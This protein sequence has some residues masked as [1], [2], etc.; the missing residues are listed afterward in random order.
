MT[1]RRRD[2]VDIGCCEEVESVVDVLIVERRVEHYSKYCLSVC[3]YVSM[4]V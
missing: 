2:M 4:Y 3:M 1:E